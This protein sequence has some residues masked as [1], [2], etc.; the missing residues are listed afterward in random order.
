MLAVPV[1]GK[2][3]QEGQKFKVSLGYVRTKQ[4]LIRHESYIVQVKQQKD[5]KLL[6]FL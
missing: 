3:E 6:F 2:W 5:G 1:L 4:K